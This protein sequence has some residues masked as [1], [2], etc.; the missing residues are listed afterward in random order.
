MVIVGEMLFSLPR[1]YAHVGSVGKVFRC[2]DP[3][4]PGE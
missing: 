1:R 4:I 2:L 3:G